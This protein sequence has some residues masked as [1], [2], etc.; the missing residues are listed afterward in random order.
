MPHLLKF[1]QRVHTPLSSSST[2]QKSSTSVTFLFGLCLQWCDV[3]STHAYAASAAAATATASTSGAHRQCAPHPEE[4][5]E[6]EHPTFS[7]ESTEI[8][9]LLYVEMICNTGALHADITH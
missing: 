6:G 3:C 7:S 9:L 2:L 1:V 8:M 5:A 4:I